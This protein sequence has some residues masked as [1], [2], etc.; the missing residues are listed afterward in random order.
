MKDFKKLTSLLI[1]AI[2]VISCASGRADPPQLFTASLQLP[3]TETATLKPP[4]SG[5]QSPT[6]TT[7]PTAKITAD[8]ATPTS[9]SR[10]ATIAARSI[11]PT[12]ED[13]PIVLIGTVIDG[14]GAELLKG[15]AIVIQDGYISS[16]GLSPDVD[17]PS[18]ATIIELQDATI[19]PGF[20]NSHVHNAY[21]PALLE[22]WA[23]AGVTTVRDVGAK[24]PFSNFHASDKFNTDPHLATVVSAG[25]LITTPGGYPIVGSDFP[26]LA[27]TNP[28]HARREV[29]QLI[30]DGAD[31][32]KIVIV[33]DVGLPTLSLDMASAIVETAHQRGVPVT[34]H[35][36]SLND[37]KRA[38]AAG[39]DDIAHIVAQERVPVEVLEQMVANDVYWVPTLE[40]FGGHD[41][42]NLRAFL[43]L[44]GNVALGN[45][46]GMLPGIEIGMPMQEIEM[47]QAAGM[48]PMEI[49]LAATRNAAHVCNLEDLLGT[50]EA[51][52]IADILV[53]NGNPLDDLHALM[54][55]RLVIHQG[56][57]IRDSGE[58]RPEGLPP[59]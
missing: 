37:L 8:P 41:G 24:F 50:L 46:G 7:A 48:S 4:P 11:D 6:L 49:I 44:G 20:I 45:D 26:S 39:V 59:K 17:I 9:I 32:I 33:S 43:A 47:M 27:V 30:S 10:T 3:S 2:M 15:S 51:G 13:T 40:P 25:P 58:A 36:N 54:E 23:Q 57:I 5:H 14:T 1:L 19:L 16:L 22:K 28:E 38:L 29:T 42:G 21:I 52:K 18:E 53:V 31:V 56:V 34:A 12:A 35:V 55:V